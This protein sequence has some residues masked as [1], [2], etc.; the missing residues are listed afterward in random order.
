MVV[1]ELSLSTS[2][3]LVP[4]S[5]RKCGGKLSALACPNPA[6][7]AHRQSNIHSLLSRR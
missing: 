6:L 1:V 3:F 4:G 7:A 2:L 5:S